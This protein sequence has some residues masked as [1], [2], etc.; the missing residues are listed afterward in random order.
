MEVYQRLL[1]DGPAFGLAHQSMARLYE[2]LGDVDASQRHAALAKQSRVPL[3]PNQNAWL[4][5]ISR[6]GVSNMDNAARA[7]MLLQNR[8]IRPAADAFELAVESDP[9]N[10]NYRVN[11]VAIYGMLKQLD[12]AQE[13]Y[14]AA[15]RLGGADAKVHL[16]MGTIQLGARRFDEAEAAY[17]RALAADGATIKAH[18]GLARIAIA[19][20]DA[21]RAE[22]FVRQAK[23]LEPLNPLVYGELVRA[24][25]LQ[26]RLE[27][28]AS[29]AEDGVQ[30]SEGRTAISLLR[31]LA[32]IQEEARR[33]GCGAQRVGPCENGSRAQ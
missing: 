23:V 10:V 4:A 3:P 12:K 17:M 14:Q 26:G 31:T 19:R 29:A 2:K 22:G 28:A 30:F 20:G 32:D 11:L 33:H 21:A 15:L 6:L 7:R 16:N 9:Q 13:H 5:A 18:L 1:D 8:L 27:D 24:L 25:R